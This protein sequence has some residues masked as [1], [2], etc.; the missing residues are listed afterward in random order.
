MKYLLYS[1]IIFS[2]KLYGQADEVQRS[3]NRVTAASEQFKHELNAFP[4]SPSKSTARAISEAAVRLN[5]AVGNFLITCETQAKSSVNSPELRKAFQEL[6]SRI[7]QID[8][9]KLVYLSDLLVD[10]NCFTNVKLC[11]FVFRHKDIIRE[12]NYTY[13][14]GINNAQSSYSRV[15]SESDRQSLYR[16]SEALEKSLREAEQKEI[17][18]SKRLAE[19]RIKKEQEAKIAAEKQRQ[20]D[21][22][23]KI[24]KKRWQE[25]KKAHTKQAYESYLKTGII[26]FYVEKAKKIVEHWDH[27]VVHV[28]QKYSVF[29]FELYKQIG[30]NPSEKVYTFSEEEFNKECS[31]FY[32]IKELYLNGAFQSFPAELYQNEGIEVL[33]LKLFFPKTN[34]ESKPTGISTLI[35]TLPNV[36][37]LVIE[38]RNV[39]D[40]SFLTAYKKVTH[41]E[42]RG[43][44]DQL[45]EFI[46]S[47]YKLQTLKVSGI[48]NLETLSDDLRLLTELKEL[49][50]DYSSSKNQRAIKGMIP[51]L[52]KLTIKF[53]SFNNLPDISNLY[54]NLE[55]LSL[56]GRSLWD[57]Y[58]VD[59]APF[60]W[61]N[62]K[63]TALHIDLPEKNLSQNTINAIG[64]LK[65]LQKLML[66]VPTDADITPLYNLSEIGRAH[67]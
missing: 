2:C 60:L 23:E 21:E 16:M 25:A 57:I 26:A 17:A 22:A 37:K 19:E 36:K 33:S 67:V 20:R 43:E 34:T 55:S 53:N 24:D 15:K 61:N 6:Y 59:F 62:S 27:K 54:Q 13:I 12:Y 65:T 31:Y 35:R 10:A 7:E 32:N 56:T 44:H 14:N 4:A 5:V 18:E 48:K 47:L 11:N 8:L 9:D 42:I 39:Q 63:L 3:Y 66:N 45:P 64:S 1:L 51:T 29:D 38:S 41:L 40:I 28:Y 58:N 50:I 49:E 30:M 46:G 52:K